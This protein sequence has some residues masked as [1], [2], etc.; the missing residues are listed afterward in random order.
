LLFILACSRGETGLRDSEKGCQSTLSSLA[1]SPENAAKLAYESGDRKYYYYITGGELTAP[2]VD[3]N[4][5]SLGREIKNEKR[6]KMLASIPDVVES[7]ECFN[8]TMA[9]PEYVKKYNETMKLLSN[10]HIRVQN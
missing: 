10:A 4:L 3:L 1:V 5:S 9:V 8:L 7:E 6:F 2:G